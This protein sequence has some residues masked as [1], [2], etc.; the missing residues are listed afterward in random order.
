LEDSQHI[1]THPKECEKTCLAEKQHQV[2]LYLILEMLSE[3][4]LLAT[5]LLPPGIFG[6][7]KNQKQ[8]NN[9]L[10]HPA[11]IHTAGAKTGKQILGYLFI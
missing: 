10:Q 1:I 8:N 11:F 2:L 6:I 4:V 9:C 7:Y 5:S 3:P